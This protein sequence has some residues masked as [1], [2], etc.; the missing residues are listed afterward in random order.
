[1]ATEMTNDG[2]APSGFEGVEPSEHVDGDSPLQARIAQRRK[3]LQ[4]QRTLTIDVPGYEGILM[5]EYRV[6]PWQT[7]RK[8]VDRH[9][10]QRDEGLRELYIAADGLM[11]ACENLYEIKPPNDTKVALDVVWGIAAANKLGIELEPGTTARQALLAI[12]EVDSRIVGHYSELVSWQQGENQE[13]D[14]ELARDFTT[15]T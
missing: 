2:S 5:A 7:I 3:V 6:L 1:M 8:N 9:Q 10:R 4:S 11:M 15:T 13:L 14:E 12:F